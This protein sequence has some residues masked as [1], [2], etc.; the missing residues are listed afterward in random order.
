MVKKDP[1]TLPAN[2]SVVFHIVIMML[3]AQA[4]TD[5]LAKESKKGSV[6]LIDDDGDSHMDSGDESDDTTT[7]AETPEPQSIPNKTSPVAPSF[8]SIG[9]PEVP[10][11]EE[12]QRIPKPSQLPAQPGGDA[13]PASAKVEGLL[14]TSES[15]LGR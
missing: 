7:G 2:S 10:T 9:S 11:H 5:I 4:S 15:P 12:L 3:T 6:Q 13:Y 8:T 1:Q 14:D